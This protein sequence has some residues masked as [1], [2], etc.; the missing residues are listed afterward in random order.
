MTMMVELKDASKAYQ[1]VPAV[2][3]VDLQVR[4]GERL[5]VIGPNGAGKSTLFGMIAGEHRPTGGSVWFEG[6]DVTSHHS[7]RRARAGMSRTF[8]VARLLPTMTVREN[9]F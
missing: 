6:R 7:S 9:L 3:G 1:G 5:A 4:R 8:Q 2:K